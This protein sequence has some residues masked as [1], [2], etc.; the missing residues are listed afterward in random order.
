MFKP[1]SIRVGTSAYIGT[2]ATLWIGGMVFFGFCVLFANVNYD[3]VEAQNNPKLPGG[4]GYLTIERE[5]EMLTF[6]IRFGALSVCGILAVV[7][8]TSPGPLIP[9]LQPS[10]S[11]RTIAIEN[12]TYATDQN[13][14]RYIIK[15][16]YN[17]AEACAAVISAKRQPNGSIR[18]HCANGMD[19]AS[20]AGMAETWPSGC[21]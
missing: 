21:H 14:V 11:P 9:A 15:Q 8:F 16:D 5:R 18:A 7:V 1:G 12:A 13:V 4:P 2:L 6:L 10:S 3:M 19:R 17:F 20:V